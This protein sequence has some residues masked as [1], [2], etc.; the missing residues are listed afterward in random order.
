VRRAVATAAIALSLSGCA[1]SRFTMPSDAGVP[2]ADAAAAWQQASSACAGVRSM[3][4]ELALSGR[5][6]GTRLRGRIQAGFDTPGRIRLEG[7]A[8][9]GQPIFILAADAARATL[10]LP[11]DERVVTAAS[12]SEILEALAGVRLEPDTLRAV[13]AGCVT[14][15]APTGATEHGDVARF[16]FAD[17]SAVFARRNAAGWRIV[18]GVARPFL[19]EYPDRQSAGLWPSRVRISRDLPGGDSVDLTIGLAQIETNMT[20][21]PE[22]FRVD[23]P[24][25]AV[26]MTVD[27]LRQ[28]GPLGDGR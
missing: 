1:A 12:A 4:A 17:G 7:V 10:L 20:L 26:P 13:L 5:A 25:S 22:A 11:R 14:T 8:P 24:P 2:M 9:F 23:V 19:V 16:A 28:A 18:A 15:G 6:A 27:Q 3:T 21:P